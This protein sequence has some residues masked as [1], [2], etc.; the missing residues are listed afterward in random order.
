MLQTNILKYITKVFIQEK[1]IKDVI[2]RVLNKK[3]L[4]KAP[5]IALS[6]F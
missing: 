4:Y 3:L 1:Y 5:I 2:L 6:I